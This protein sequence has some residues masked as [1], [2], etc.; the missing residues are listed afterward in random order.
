MQNG[1]EYIM[2]Y[3]CTST[4][5]G[6]VDIRSAYKIVE[7]VPDFHVVLY[8]E[9]VYSYLVRW[10]WGTIY[11]FT[12]VMTPQK[13]KACAIHDFCLTW[14]SGIMWCPGPR[15]GTSLAKYTVASLLC[16]LMVRFRLDVK[17]CMPLRHDYNFPVFGDWES[18]NCA[19]Y[20]SPAWCCMAHSIWH[21]SAICTIGHFTSMGI[22]AVIAWLHTID[23]EQR[24]RKRFGSVSLSTIRPNSM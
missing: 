9:K 12:F 20:R 3:A 14:A 17:M 8:M 15:E 24:S 4:A 13:I 7:S 11:K 22:G 2:M 1:S 21:W 5:I 6:S 19:V 18:V 23:L 16:C 10:M